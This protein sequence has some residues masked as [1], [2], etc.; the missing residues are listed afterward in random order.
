L[1]KFAFGCSRLWSQRRPGI[2]REQQHHMIYDYLIVGCGVAGLNAARYIPADKKVLL[3][4][5]KSP[6]QCNTFFAQGGVATATNE[7]DIDS[8]VADTLQAGA[9]QNNKDRVRT[10]SSHSIQTIYELIDDGMEFDKNP[11]GSLAYTKEAA[12]SKSRVLHANGDATGRQLHLFLLKQ[13]RHKIIDNSIVVDILSQDG[14]CYGVELLCDNRIKRVFAHHTILASGGVGSIYQYHTNS[15]TI[16]GDIQGICAEK[17]ITLADMHLMQFHPTVYVEQTTAQKQLLTEALRGEGAKIVDEDGYAFLQDYHSSAELA[18]RDIVSRAIF[19][20]IKKTESKIYL[21][22]SNFTKKQFKRR[23]P[24]IYHN[25]VDMGYDL[26]ND[27]VPISPAFHYSMGGVKVD[28]YGLVS[29]YKNLFAI[30][31][32]AR[33]G[34]HGANRLASNSLLEGLVFSKLAVLQSMK[35]QF[36]MD[37]EKFTNPQKDYIL[38]KPQDKKLKEKLRAIMWKHVGIIR[39]T[40]DLKETLDK[41]QKISKLDIGRLLYLRLLVAISIVKEAVAN[42]SSVGAHFIQ[43]K[44]KR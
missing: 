30:G 28:R 18:P 23:F 40:E 21:D 35:N 41:L 12:H 25:F 19:D 15:T 5:K 16:S 31:E 27:K 34:V 9:F 44:E 13:C 4:C 1:L 14:V 3:V 7:R 38:Q 29:D 32:V 2:Y 26:P 10:M 43:K 20:Y 17:G 6:W 24:N 37:I 42:T 33:T 22:L 8:H 11:D 39:N 36:H